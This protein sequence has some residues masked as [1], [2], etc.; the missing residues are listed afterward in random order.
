MR[1]IRC[2]SYA[3]IRRVTEKRGRIS[4]ILQCAMA[5]CVVVFVAAPPARAATTF[6]VTTTADT[7]DGACTATLCSFRDALN[8]AD[9]SPGST[10]V[11]PAGTYTASMLAGNGVWAPGGQYTIQ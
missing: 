5:A 7:N 2:S 3:R 4:L 10:V 9:G 8:A 6:T 1:L 11:V